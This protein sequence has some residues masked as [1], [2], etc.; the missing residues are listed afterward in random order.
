MNDKNQMQ[1]QVK[2]AKQQRLISGNEILKCFWIHFGI[3]FL[4]SGQFTFVIEER[5]TYTFLR[6]QGKSYLNISLLHM[7]K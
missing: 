7:C 4:L 2:N 5:G 1:I 3:C 6:K